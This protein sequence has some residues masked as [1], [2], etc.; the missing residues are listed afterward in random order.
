MFSEKAIQSAFVKAAGNLKTLQGLRHYVG[1]NKRL[2]SYLESE[3]TMTPT[4]A[5][6]ALA[7]YVDRWA[8]KQGH[9]AQ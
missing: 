9:R 1:L 7:T 5:A 6:E 2:Q 3:P 8:L 4:E